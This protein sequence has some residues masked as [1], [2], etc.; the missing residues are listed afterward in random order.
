M[1]KKVLII[2]EEALVADALTKRLRT[3]GY[4]PTVAQGRSGAIATFE[5]QRPDLVILSLT[6]P[7]DE[8]LD[9]C[10]ELRARPLGALV[11][12]LFI[13]TGAESVTSVKEA[14]TAGAVH[15]FS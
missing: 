15:F 12:I 2:E 8:S 13:G 6:L 7:G 11:P 4:A 3:R 5:S 14:I 9:L 1:Q 10:R